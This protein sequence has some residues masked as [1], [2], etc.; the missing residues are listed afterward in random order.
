MGPSSDIMPRNITACVGGANFV[1]A[2]YYV[3][4]K[5]ER[6]LVVEAPSC[7]TDEECWR[8]HELLKEKYHSGMVII[9]GLLDEDE[10]RSNWAYLVENRKGDPC[11]MYQHKRIRL[12]CTPFARSIP[13][14][15]IRITKWISAEERH[16]IW[17]GSEV[18]LLM[19][20]D[21]IFCAKRVEAFTA[22]YRAIQA[23][24]LSFEVLGHV[25][26]DDR[27]IGIMT[28]PAYGRMVQ[29]RDRAL[30]Y[31]AVAKLH[32]HGVLYASP[33]HAPFI[34]ISNGKVRF[35]DIDN[36]APLPQPELT[37]QAKVWWDCLDKSFQ[38]LR[39]GPNIHTPPRSRYVTQ[40]IKVFPSIP[41]PPRPFSNAII[42]FELHYRQFYTSDGT[43]IKRRRQHRTSRK[44]PAICLAPDDSL[45]LLPQDGETDMP[46]A[47]VLH[48]RPSRAA[49]LFHPYSHNPRT[50]PLLPSSEESDT[51]SIVQVPD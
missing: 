11:L 24:D 7:Y 45:Q 39:A 50:K 15:E 17:N 10:F 40:R 51:S 25:V 38:E 30:V 47:A 1:R 29:Y 19:A 4:L 28:Q 31:D 14:S 27:I 48:S 20:W 6:L 9:Q 44:R 26:R 5:N 23:L 37:R 13:E 18:D 3:L 22:G 32:R 46:F 35:L 43:L 34:M 8:E 49:H 41:S 16:G 21:D 2:M 33:Q 12:A 36:M 42:T